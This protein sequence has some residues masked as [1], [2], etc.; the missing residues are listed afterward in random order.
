MRAVVIGVL[1]VISLAGL[2]GETTLERLDHFYAV[3][4]DPRE[5]IRFF[6]EDLELP[7]I[8]PFEEF[9]TF[10]SGGISFGN[11]VF[12]VARFPDHGGSTEF[13]GIAFLPRRHTEGMREEFSRL[14]VALSE[15]RSY[16]DS[17]GI[18]EKVL[19][20]NT[21]LPELS[22]GRPLASG[23]YSVISTF[24]CDFI[25]R[26]SEN[27]DRRIALE[28]LK[29]RDGGV[30]GI[31]ELV[32]IQIDATDANR[33]RTAWAKA[34][35]DSTSR[36][37]VSLG[38]VATPHLLIK[39]AGEDRIHSVVLRVRSISEARTWLEANEML[40]EAGET[41][42]EIASDELQGLVFKLIE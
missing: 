31:I 6:N 8:W 38:G 14:G 23:R 20:V 28:K 41:W 39:P 34:L 30:L 33:R 13:L 18:D 22:S 4:N 21:T 17:S 11:V 2:A 9:K 16:V 32:E 37:V 10:A 19:W 26:E 7:V 35:Q 25:D 3:S 15:S 12:E 24:V 36:E 1:W 42:I 27:R 5:L 40:G 29:E